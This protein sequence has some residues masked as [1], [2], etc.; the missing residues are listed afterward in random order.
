MAQTLVKLKVADV[1]FQSAACATG[2][3]GL[4]QIAAGNQLTD[5]VDT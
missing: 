3:V 1:V 4:E 5:S 2:E